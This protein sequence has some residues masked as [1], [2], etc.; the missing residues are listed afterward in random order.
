MIEPS[1]E[2]LF[3]KILVIAVVITLV[4][5]LGA[6][7]YVVYGYIVPPQDPGLLPAVTPT[8]TI[9]ITPTS[10]PT[11]R[12]T[13]TPTPFPQPTLQINPTPVPTDA[14]TV[15][16][17]D[18]RITD[19]LKIASPPG[20]WEHYIVYDEIV[21][22]DNFNVHLYDISAMSDLIISTG[23]IRSFGAI[24]SGK[25]A[26]QNLDSNRIYLYDLTDKSQRMA[27]PDNN[28]PRKYPE[29][30]DNVLIY[31][32][33]D[34]GSNHVQ[35]NYDVFSV[36][37]YM[38][39]DG[40]YN[41]WS[42]NV[43]EPNELMGSG[44]MIVWWD[45]VNDVKR[46]VLY[47][48]KKISGKQISPDGVSCD[49]PRIS[50]NIVVYHGASGGEHHIYT[51]DITTGSRK[52]ITSVGRQYTADISDNRI[53]YDDNREGNWNIYLYDRSTQSETQLTTESHDQM[54]P[55]IA[56]NFVIFMNNK[57]GGW[58]IYLKTL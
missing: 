50:G 43:P 18:I 22:T 12:P 30:F 57:N 24:G 40:T 44:N 55:Q 13:P 9:S 25:V 38:M 56:G 39:M 33:N 51:Y 10:L 16:D 29:I 35:G 8:G 54:S 4:V 31:T 20:L 42:A 14:P 45:V 2:S 19:G 52:Q 28:I 21:G 48:I 15:Y 47:D 11:K 49:H 53:V 46:I 17:Y 6:C 37:S 23:N 58:D 5:I 36:Y 3:S 27:T 32:G 1:D 26:L 7:A 41:L 34:G